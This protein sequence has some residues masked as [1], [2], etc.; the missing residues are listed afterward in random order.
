MQVKID[1]SERFHVITIQEHTLSA[2]MT[3]LIENKLSEV[4]NKEVKNVVLN[5]KDIHS[6]D[7]AAAELLIKMQERFY[8][9]DASFVICE[10]PE[11][12]SKQLRTSGVLDRMNIVPT[13]SEAGDIILMEEIERELE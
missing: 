3:E 10:L 6:M 11:A 8:A 1:T 2:N 12:V 4:L 7:N 9:E 5:L 13:E